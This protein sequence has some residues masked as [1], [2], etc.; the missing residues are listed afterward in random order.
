MLF[1][2]ICLASPKSK[3]S[4]L[5]NPLLN[6]PVKKTALNILL[7]PALLIPVQELMAQT[8]FTEMAAQV[9][10]DHFHLSADLMGGGVA[11]FDYNNDGWEDIWITG[12][13]DRDVLYENDGDG[14][15]TE[16]G[17]Q[18]GL[19]V[20]ASIHTKA[21]VTGD[22][23]NDGWRDVFL[24]TRDGSPNL[25][26]LNN[27][28]GT[29]D[30][31][32]NFAGMG[33]DIAWSMAAAMADFNND[34]WLDI[35]VGNYVETF[36][37]IIDPQTNQTIGYAH[38]GQPNFL[39]L[40]NGDLTFTEVGGT[41]GTA[42]EGTALAVMASD[43]SDDGLTDLL[44]AN[45]Y[46][47][48]VLP[49]GAFRNGGG[50]FT[51]ENQSNGMDIGIYAMGIAAGDMD[52][53]GDLDYYFTNLG[54]NVLMENVDGVFQDVATGA[55][56]EN[57]YAGDN[58]T[59]GW[60]TAFLDVDND[61]D[62][63][64]FVANGFIPALGFNQTEVLNPDK[65]F[66]NNAWPQGELL[67][68]TDI[69]TGA[70]LGDTGFARGFAHGDF[71]KDGDQDLVVV[72]VSGTSDPSL[73]HKV[74]FYRNDL[75]DGGNWLDVKLE[76]TVSNRD[77]FGAKVKISVGGRSWLHEVASG[78]SHASQNTSIAHF[79][80]GNAET[81]DSLVILWPMGGRQTLTD[82]LPNQIRYVQEDTSLVTAASEAF[83]KAGFEISV[84]PNPFHDRTQIY[85]SNPENRSLT[86]IL[87]D[88]AGRELR[89]WTITG[90]HLEINGN[91]FLPGIY[92]LKTFFD[93][94]LINTLKLSVV[95]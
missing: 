85:F 94:K 31:I 79:G 8:A 30:D 92:F 75:A 59:V 83:P 13:N 20:T 57:T 68:F 44:V 84:A 23:N 9:G 7:F 78:S 27:G 69:S 35:Y 5:S 2:Q 32:A 46:G 14:T 12:G 45:D 60:G 33:D 81:V 21:V 71:D 24:A 39:Y 38:T 88:M 64:L 70:G 11:V 37:Y 91:Q 95:P 52:Q 51:N 18:A 26:L 55:G 25:L 90:Q 28:D 86:F 19:L 61:S 34:G 65:L 3:G 63:D 41:S 1:W 50:V 89:T 42:D 62:L 17:D 87:A 43:F 6:S 77:A 76:G 74:L 36:E 10:I 40:N 49:N 80:L 82:I 4:A 29:F 73:A 16:V 72:R 66:L 58:F 22:I 56:V 53:D 67:S 54:R 48:W 15:F 47:E 93:K